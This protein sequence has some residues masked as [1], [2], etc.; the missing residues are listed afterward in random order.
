M[1]NLLFTADEQETQKGKGCRPIRDSHR[2][3]WNLHLDLFVSHYAALHHQWVPLTASMTLE[4]GLW[5]AKKQKKRDKIAQNFST[6]STSS[7]IRLYFRF[8]EGKQLERLNDYQKTQ[9]SEERAALKARPAYFQGLVYFSAQ[10]RHVY[11]T[12]HCSGGSLHQEGLEV[13]E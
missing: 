4:S 12:L 9:S 8:Q 13:N 2:R 5:M 3:T 6:L 1:S 11:S 10:P 7:I